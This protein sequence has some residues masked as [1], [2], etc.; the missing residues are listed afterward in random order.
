MLHLTGKQELGAGLGLMLMSGPWEQPL[1]S[2]GGG[3]TCMPLAEISTQE[4]PRTPC[5]QGRGMWPFQSDL[6]ANGGSPR[7]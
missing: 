1:V 6:G 3:S 7:R 4:F 2:V 5:S